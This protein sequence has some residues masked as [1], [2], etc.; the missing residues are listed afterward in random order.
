MRCV[1]SVAQQRGGQKN[2]EGEKLCEVTRE[3]RG[4]EKVKDTGTIRG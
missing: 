3:I 2:R 4:G 1:K